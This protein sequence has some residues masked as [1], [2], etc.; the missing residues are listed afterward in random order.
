MTKLQKYLNDIKMSQKELAR[1]VDVHT[2]SM[3]CICNGNRSGK[4]ST[5]YKI[6]QFLN[7]ELDMIYDPNDYKED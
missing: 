3:S 2:S 6:C 1:A 7:V 4:I 5:W